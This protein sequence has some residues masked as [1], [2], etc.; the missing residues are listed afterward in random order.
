MQKKTKPWVTTAHTMMVSVE[1]LSQ[2]GV[3]Y[4]SDT[5]GRGVNADF[6]TMEVLTRA[7]NKLGLHGLAYGVH[8]IGRTSGVGSLYFEFVDSD[9]KD[10]AREILSLA[11]SV[12]A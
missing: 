10:R 3:P 1:E 4:E 9:V 8:F 11:V 5:E 2:G 7:A 6:G 12:L